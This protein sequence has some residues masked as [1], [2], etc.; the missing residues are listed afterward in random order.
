MITVAIVAILAAVALPAYNGY[1]QKSR[2]TDAYSALSSIAL[3]QER[4]RANNTTY[5]TLAQL[6][7]S[8]NSVDGHYTLA[9]SGNTASGFTATATA[10]AGGSQVN[11]KEGATACTPL[12]LTVS[13]GATTYAPA[14]CWKK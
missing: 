11:D 1:V 4:W 9:V 2:R 14:S 6:G 5:G 12:T 3:Q 13:G 10:K 8:S 7:V